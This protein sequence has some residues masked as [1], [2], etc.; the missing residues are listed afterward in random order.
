MKNLIF[1]AL[2]VIYI[3]L[4]YT[5]MAS[6]N[7]ALINNNMKKIVVTYLER[8]LKIE[9]KEIVLGYY[10]EVTLTHVILKEKTNTSGEVTYSVPSRENGASYIFTF[11]FSEENIKKGFAMRIPSD[12]LYGGQDSIFLTLGK[13]KKWYIKNLGAPIQWMNLPIKGSQIGNDKFD[14]NI[15]K[16]NWATQEASEIKRMGFVNG[17]MKSIGVEDIFLEGSIIY[18]VIK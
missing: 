6:E 9:G 11:A 1:A 17:G 18:I 16:Y 2:A 7:S 15:L 3:T 12:S 4:F 8:N 10:D 5:A 14:V 13:E